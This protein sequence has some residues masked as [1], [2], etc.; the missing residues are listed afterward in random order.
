MSIGSVEFVPLIVIGQVF[1]P[2]KGSG[3]GVH[4]LNVQIGVRPYHR[5]G[6]ATFPL[7]G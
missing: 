1:I 6:Y 4:H 2:L 7:M 3:N 5:E